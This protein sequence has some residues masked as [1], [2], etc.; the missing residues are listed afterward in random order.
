M[1]LKERREREK[2]EVRGKILDAAR[3]LFVARGLRGGDDAED[4]AGDRVLADRDLPPLPRQGSGHQRDLR[5]RLPRSSQAASARSPRSPIRS[6]ACGPPGS[7]TPTSRCAIPNH[8]RLM[9]MTPAPAALAGGER[10]RGR[11]PRPGRLRLR[12]VDGGRGDRRRGGSGRSSTTPS[13]SRRS[14]GP[15]STAGS[16]C[17]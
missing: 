13:S 8:Y 2:E 7:P 11:Q 3:E 17:G 12:A 15:P 16:P 5:H 14:S 9:F 6:S 4:R 10:H 1:G